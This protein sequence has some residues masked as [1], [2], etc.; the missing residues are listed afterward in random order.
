MNGYEIHRLERMILPAE[1]EQIFLLYNRLTTFVN[2][3]A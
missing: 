1:K 3:I 2:R